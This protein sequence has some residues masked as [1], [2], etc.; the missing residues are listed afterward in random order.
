M[1]KKMFLNLSQI[2]INKLVY[3]KRSMYYNYY[4]IVYTYYINNT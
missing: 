4:V 1:I 3:L 2:P